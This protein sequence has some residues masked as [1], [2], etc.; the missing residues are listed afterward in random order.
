MRRDKLGT[1]NIAMVI[2]YA[3]GLRI[4]VHE[5][6]RRP[7]IFDHDIME[8]AERIYH[9]TAVRRLRAKS[10][11]LSLEGLTLLAYEPDL[12]EPEIEDKYRRFQTAVD[13]IQS[14]YRTGKLMREMVLVVSHAQGRKKLLTT[15]EGYAN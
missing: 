13:E 14:R 3:D 8:T 2:A 9:K 10:I 7:R 12:F 5:K 4:E 11:S 6:A 15:S 1:T